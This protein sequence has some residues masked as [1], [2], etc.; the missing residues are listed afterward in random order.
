MEV[1]G[2]ERIFV[3]AGT[4]NVGIKFLQD[5]F[6][7]MSHIKTPATN[8]HVKKKKERKKFLKEKKQTLCFFRSRQFIDI[9][10]Y[11]E[12]FTVVNL[13]EV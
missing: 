8:A 1:S 13:N 4:V 11:A 3:C 6:Y 9:Q 10:S 2:L 7:F 5:M 12:D